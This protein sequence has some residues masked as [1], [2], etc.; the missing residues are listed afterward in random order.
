[1]KMWLG[2]PHD[3]GHCVGWRSSVQSGICHISVL[4]FGGVQNQ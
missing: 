4:L 3:G 2:P 1:M